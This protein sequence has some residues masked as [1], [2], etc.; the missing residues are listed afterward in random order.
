MQPTK[1]ETPLT[2]IAIQHFSCLLGVALMQGLQ[3]ILF[4]VVC[5]C[6]LLKRASDSAQKQRWIEF[7]L[8]VFGQLVRLQ[9]EVVGRFLSA[10]MWNKVNPIRQA[11]HTS[12]L[13]K[14]VSR[15]NGWTVERKSPGA[16]HD[17][18][19]FSEFEN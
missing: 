19:E 8:L 1:T 11:E 16:G 12:L 5:R 17:L 13:I 6:Q 10:C 15:N 18:V 7:V 9:R 2:V 4:P 3:D 14:K